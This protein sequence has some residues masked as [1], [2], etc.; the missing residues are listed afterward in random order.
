MILRRVIAHFRK[1]EWAA[2]DWQ[3]TAAEV[4]EWL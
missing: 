2:E 4:D 3:Q 1:Q